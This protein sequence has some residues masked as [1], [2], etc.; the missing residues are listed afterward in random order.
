MTFG[1]TRYDD[2]TR[3]AGALRGR[4][5]QRFPTAKRENEVFV[6]RSPLDY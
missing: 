2:L 3:I 4:R 1:T 6:R 5:G